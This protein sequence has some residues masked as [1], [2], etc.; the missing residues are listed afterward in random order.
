MVR[1]I[2]QGGLAFHIL[3][4][5]AS[6]PKARRSNSFT[7]ADTDCFVVLCGDSSVCTTLVHTSERK[8]RL[9]FSL[10]KRISNHIL[11]FLDAGF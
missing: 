11:D 4:V 7:L 3:A 9:S 1:A 6:P 2:R 5:N 8:K 10:D